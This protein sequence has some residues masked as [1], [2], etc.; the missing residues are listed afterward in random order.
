MK[1]VWVIGFGTFGQR[2]VE[3][4]S[5]NTQY[6]LTIVDITFEQGQY[7]EDSR[8]TYFKCDGVMFLKE[9][10]FAKQS[11]DW[12][13]PALPVHL[14]AE[15][16]LIRLQNQGGQSVNIPTALESRVPNPI[17]ISPSLLCVSYADFVCPDNCSE[18]LNICPVTNEPRKGNMYDLLQETSIEPFQ[19]KVIRSFQLGPGIGGYRPKQLFD[20]LNGLQTN[21]GQFLICTACRCHGIITGFEKK[22]EA[23]PC[24]ALLFCCISRQTV[25]V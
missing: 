1:H 12:I 15:W 13:I 24:T 2:A 25:I 19:T 14:A 6:N 23:E 16:C 8:H 17:W 7:L 9:Y 21:K 20:L 10:L 11:P 22:C 4:L 5:K 18:P 3:Y